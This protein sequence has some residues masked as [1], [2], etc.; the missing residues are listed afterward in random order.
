MTTIATI[1]SLRKLICARRNRIAAIYKR[2]EEITV[3][4]QFMTLEE[5]EAAK[6]EVQDL[7]KEITEHENFIKEA[8]KEIADFYKPATCIA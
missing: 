7:C 2:A 1:N 6:N 8:K 3:K 4:A 5:L